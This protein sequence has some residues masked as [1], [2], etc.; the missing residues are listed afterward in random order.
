MFHMLFCKTIGTVVMVRF[1]KRGALRNGGW[2][3]V[4]VMTLSPSFP[5]VLHAI[6]IPGTIPG[7]HTIHS[8][9]YYSYILFL[10]WKLLVHTILRE[11]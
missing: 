3:G 8:F 7:S 11:R 2:A 10:T 1:A 9:L 6:L 4:S 5:I